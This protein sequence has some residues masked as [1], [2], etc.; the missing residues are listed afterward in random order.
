MSD[1]GSSFERMLSDLIQAIPNVIAALLL[2]L[3][4]WIV[5]VIVKNVVQ[6]GFV[7]LGAH[8]GLGKTS[9]VRDE[10][11]GES[12][13]HSI[14]K[15]FYFLVFILFIPAILDALSMDSV[16]EPI[17]NMM[18]K[19][20]G[21]IPNIIAAAIIL[22]IGIFIAKL[23]K[24][25][26]E[27]FFKSLNLDKWFNKVSPSNTGGTEAQSTLSNVL[28]N[29]IFII[30]LIPVITIALEAL[31]IDTISEPIQDVLNDVLMMIPNIFVAI[32]LVIVGYYLAKLLG[33]LL[34]SLLE[35]TGINKIYSSFG[36]EDETKNPPFDLAK[37]LGTITKILIILFFTVEALNVLELEVLNTI[38]NALI[39]YLPFLL[40]A[41]LILGAGLY[42]A[43]LLNNWIR[44]YTNSPLSAE[45]VKYVVI[46]FAVF[47]TLDQLQFAKTIVN[48]AFLL[49]LGGLM[50]AFAISFG[51]GGR[52]FAKN[53][54]EKLEEKLNRK[55]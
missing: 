29:I 26:F 2:L 30:I 46:V 42:L 41:L 43:N 51:I 14:G 34:T 33:N 4:A 50:V 3:L 39:S 20:L 55:E 17:T 44:K 32:I 5:A 12:I 45:I 35:G 21:F 15:I 13:L 10:K 22:T 8:K 36:V 47:M 31:N 19:L 48:L 40:S 24:D 18:D 54:L 11:H 7:K 27:K 38:G 28:A 6:K 49:I 25:L 52:D 16:S 23:I 9:F 1:L 53:Q 37:A